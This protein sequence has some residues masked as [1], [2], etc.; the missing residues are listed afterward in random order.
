MKKTKLSTNNLYLTQQNCSFKLIKPYLRIQAQ[1]ILFTIFL[2][3]ISVYSS[4]QNAST[5]SISGT[6]STT[7]ISNNTATVVDNGL[8]VSANGNITGFTV[9]IT[10]SYTSGDILAYT[11]SLPSGVTAGSFNTTSRSLQ[12]SG[13]TS[14]ASWQT[15]LRTVTL[16]T[17]SATC[18]PEQRQVS[19]TAGAK[20]FNNLN[21]H[22]YE[23]SANGSTW[24]SGFSNAAS[25]SYFGRLGYM[26]TI[27]SQ[28]E[29]SFIS[30]ILGADSWIGS[31][32]AFNYINAATGTTTFANQTA[33]EGKWYWVSGPEKGLNFSNGNWGSRVNVSGVYSNWN[34][35]EPN[36]YNGS[37]DYGEIYVA[38]GTWNDLPGTDG[39]RTV[40][41]YGGFSTDDVSSAVVFTR[42][43]LISG[44]PS[45][46]ITGG[47]VTVCTGSN[48]TTLTL[49][50][51]ASG[52]SVVRWESSFDD[53]LNAGTSISNTSTSLT[54][55]NITQN[56]YYRAIVNTSGCSSL[57]TS[58]T[59]INVNSA[60]A[61]NIVGDNTTICNGANINFTLNGY[62]GTI[63]KWQVSTSSTFASNVT[64]ISNTTSAL[65]YQLNTAGT[66]YFRAVVNSCSNT[67]N[68]NIFQIAVIS[69]TAPVG[70]SISSSNF[71]G[72]SNSGTLT[73]SG[74]T[75]TISKWELST[76]GGVVWSNVANTTAT[77]SF[78]GITASRRYR[79]V[80]TN[81]SCGTTLSDIGFINVVI[82]PTAPTVSTTSSTNCGVINTTLSITAG[83]LNSATN[84]QWYSGS[85]GGT[86]EGSGTSINVSPS[87]T[88]TY[89]ARGE[90][91]S[92]GNGSC[93]SITITVLSATPPTTPT[94]SASSTANC[95]TLSTSLSIASGT[96]NSAT[97]WQW[98]SGSCGGTNVGTGTQINV[99]PTVTTTY[100]ARGEGGSCGN[101]SC[102]SIT[103]TVNPVPSA[104]SL[105][106]STNNECPNTQVSLSIQTS[107]ERVYLIPLSQLIN[108][109]SSCGNG[110]FYNNC[111]TGEP[112]FTWTDIG[113]G[114]VTNVKVEFQI[115]VECHSNIAHTT[116]LNSLSGSS[117]TAANFCNCGLPSSSPFTVNFAN[118]SGYNVGGTNQFRLGNNTTCIGYAPNSSSF[119]TGNYARVTITY[120]GNSTGLSYLWTPGNDTARTTIVSPSST[121]T[122][123]CKATN[124]FGCSATNT[125]TVTVVNGSN[126]CTAPTTPTLSTSSSTNCGA[127]NTTLSISTGTLN[128]ATN[129]QWYS[130]SCGGTSA[131]SGTSITVSPTATTTYYARGE[132]GCVTPGTCASITITVNQPTSPDMPSI[133]TSSS[134]I[135]GNQSSTLSITGGSLNGAANWQWFS[136]SCGGTSVGSGTSITV[137]PTATTT[138]YARGEGG[139]ITLGSCENSTITVTGPGVPSGANVFSGS[140]TI[141]TQTQMNAFFNSENGNKYT[142]VTGDL[143]INGNSTS[144][145]ITSLCNLSSLTE[146]SGHLL[147]QQFTQSDNPTN[148]GN[149]AALTKAGRLTIITCPSFTSISLPGLTDVAGALIIRNNHFVKTIHV[150]NLATVGGS[151]FMII[152]NH[153]AE[154]IQFSNT[155]SSFT[156]NNATENTSVDIQSNGDSAASAL[157]MDFKKIT[158]IAKDF[159]FANNKNSGVSNF[160][161]IFSGLTSVGGNM[162]IT[163]N[164]SV[165]KCCIAASTVV[166]GSRTITGNTGNCANLSAVVSDCGTL[167]KKNISNRS[168]WKNA[169]LFS[170]LSLYPSP[171]KGKFE[172]EL[173]TTQT[174]SLNLTVLDLVGRVI[175]TQSQNVSGTISIPVALDKAAAGQYIVKLELNGNVVV[176]RVQVVK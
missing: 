15:F 33:A 2:L 122:Y 75:G 41:E 22:F 68:T 120:G 8:T 78:S 92:C 10:G 175:L 1:L 42:S 54:V 114:T 147:I 88:T 14:A 48:S 165:A 106:A 82:T 5:V 34:S 118:P 139:C 136:G 86:S 143:T 126:C 117:I 149:L 84:W 137:S 24:Q 168:S 11:G 131:G 103:I 112:G 36:N 102:G 132:G 145:P 76:D 105:I 70:G 55:T 91:S 119:G 166:T 59:R 39:F 160:D 154:S 79:A 57:A 125:I 140:A 150:A 153:R 161:N 65:T 4:A 152:R 27:T 96:L 7:T 134:S 6:G 156:L 94:L 163:N 37:E 69:G 111:S 173:T 71:C 67:V 17:T 109:P 128:S 31:S 38:N 115:G 142:K 172:I 23:L 18:Y 110:S 93:G 174:G 171:N 87:V 157:T 130:G 21:G 44:A 121:T 80:L 26:A 73:L 123:S 52:G 49:S 104:P 56:T 101:G 90:G 66:Y 159:T 144:D 100:F 83:S 148:L 19:F 99:S 77:L 58:S 135:C 107:S 53:F 12:F 46:T 113:S 124:S 51:L 16:R 40:I 45:G 3:G 13:T 60:I 9:M 95:G 129:W 108:L 141:S 72:G 170:E 162:V 98:Y 151:Q 169:D 62:S 50:G 133:N 164:T 30:K 167:N 47:N 20:F 64:D 116:I 63:I 85:C 25:Q 127:Q 29:N 89:Y 74:H 28:A 32:D 176:K 61:G 97:N 43:L 35:G 146:V 81:G 158:A 155:A 138:Y